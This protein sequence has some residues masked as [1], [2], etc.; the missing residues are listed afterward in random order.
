M[1]DMRNAILQADLVNNGGTNQTAL[2]TIFAERGM[3]YFASSTGDGIAPIE[4]F[5]VPVDCVTVACGTISGKITDKSSGKGLSGVAVGVAG[6]DSGFGWDLADTTGS[7]GSFSIADV[8]FHTYP[9]LQ[10]SRKAY[11]PADLTNVVVDGAE[12]VNGKMVRDWAALE[13]GAK[14]KK[15]SP[16]D[17]TEFC[18]VGADGAFDLSL[19][20][21][22]PSDA[23]GSDEGSNFTGPR[24]V[25]VKLPK[26]VDIT[27]FA[28]ASGGTCGDGPEAG[29]KKFRIETK[30]KNGNWVTA[31]TGT[32]D[33]DGVFHVFKAKAG[34][35][36]VLYVRFTMLSNYGDPLFMDM[37]ELSVR[38]K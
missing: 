29:V 10:V 20:S 32:V 28:L 23:V 9:L 37:L 16:P 17:Y 11:E 6:L 34:K 7:N 24:K 21:G 3:G 19:G 18:G 30:A 26:V 36:N 14:L 5:S 13:G 8:P 1:L 25:T 31:L 35:K 22:W 27:S 2:W 15:S 33:N 4:D 12:T 38:G